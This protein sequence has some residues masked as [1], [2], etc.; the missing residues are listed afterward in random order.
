MLHYLRETFVSVSSSDLVFSVCFSTL[1]IQSHILMQLHRWHISPPMVL[2]AEHTNM[3]TE[4]RRA[5]GSCRYLTLSDFSAFT[6]T[7]SLIICCNVSC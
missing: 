4:E 1:C 5:E 2:S 7:S 6:A 3:H